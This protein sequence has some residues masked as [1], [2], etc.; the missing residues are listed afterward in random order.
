MPPET[1]ANPLIQLVPFALMAAIFYFIV[2]LP[3][4]KKQKAHKEKISQLKKN[5][6][7]VTAGGIHGTVVSVKDTTLIVRI[8][9]SVKIEVDREAIT[10]VKA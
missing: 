4:K 2:L 1:A 10:S 5:D 6:A 9:D 8:D 3:E 7:V